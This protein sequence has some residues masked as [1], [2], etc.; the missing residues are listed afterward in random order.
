MV[1]LSKKGLGAGR[2]E[3]SLNIGLNNGHKSEKRA[4]LYVMNMVIVISYAYMPQHVN[5]IYEL[6]VFG[7]GYRRNGRK[8]DVV[9]K[10]R[11]PIRLSSWR[12]WWSS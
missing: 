5:V 8:H 3:S 9:G 12:P 7:D 6:L 2:L 4:H 10:P 11:W 1:D